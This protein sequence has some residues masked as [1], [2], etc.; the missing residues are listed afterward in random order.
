[1]LGVLDFQGQTSRTSFLLPWLFSE[2]T[3][4]EVFRVNVGE[5]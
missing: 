1:M 5:S 3:L 4:A 2:Y